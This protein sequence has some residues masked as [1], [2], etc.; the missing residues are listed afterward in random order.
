MYW[1]SILPPPTL[2]FQVGLFHLNVHRGSESLELRMCSQGA[3]PDL[4]WREL[5]PQEIPGSQQPLSCLY[6]DPNPAEILSRILKVSGRL[7][8]SS[9]WFCTKMAKWA[10]FNFRWRTDCHWSSG[11]GKSSTSEVILKGHQRKLA[12]ERVVNTSPPPFFPLF[13]TKANK[14]RFIFVPWGLHLPELPG[15][16]WSWWA[17]SEGGHMFSVGAWAAQFPLVF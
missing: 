15:E 7:V 16:A 17:S 8:K 12:I 10:E 4:L 1:P 13:L 14:P 9:H 5:L 11:T 2:N 3:F 6:K